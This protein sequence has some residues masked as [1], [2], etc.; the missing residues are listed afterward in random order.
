MKKLS[1]IFAML[2]CLAC[3]AACAEGD[4]S[5]NPDHPLDYPLDTDW[6]S[7]VHDILPPETEYPDTTVAC[8]DCTGTGDDT[9]DDWYAVPEKPVIYLYPEVPTACDLRVI[10][11]GELT[12]TYPE[13]G[14]QG[15]QDFVAYPDGTLVFPDGKE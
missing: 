2:L 12:F 7:T 1:F 3:L 8:D 5:L 14:V 15:W 9:T 4:P 13:H 11:D 10:F 6:Q